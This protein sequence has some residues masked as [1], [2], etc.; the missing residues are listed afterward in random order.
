ML[1]FQTENL[2]MGPVSTNMLACFEVSS[3]EWTPFEFQ[4]FLNMIEGFS[5]F[6]VL[7]LPKKHTLI[8]SVNR[9]QTRSALVHK[10]MFIHISYIIECVV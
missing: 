9:T 4:T 5:P 7:V 2:T 8:I 6:G 10:D 1:D 3:E